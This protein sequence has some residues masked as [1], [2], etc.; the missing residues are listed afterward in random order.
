MKPDFFSYSSM[1]LIDSTNP[2]VA[3]VFGAQFKHSF[4]GFQIGQSDALV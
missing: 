1:M 2:D 4:V 3:T